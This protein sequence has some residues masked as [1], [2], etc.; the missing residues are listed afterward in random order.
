MKKIMRGF[1]TFLIVASLSWSLPVLGSAKGVGGEPPTGGAQYL[2]ES[3]F[4][5]QPILSEASQGYLR[6]L[7]IYFKYRE[8]DFNAEKSRISGSGVL[9]DAAVSE[10]E[11]ARTEAVESI[12][13]SGGLDIMDAAVSVVIRNCE[14]DGELIHVTAYEWTFIDYDDLGDDIV[15]VDVSGFGTTHQLTLVTDGSACRILGDVYDESD[16]DGFS[17]SKSEVQPQVESPSASTVSSDA[18]PGYDPGAA[19][20]YADT[21]VWN[22]ADMSASG[23]FEE[24]YNPEYYNFNSVGGDCTNYVS[25]CLYAGG[26]PQTPGAHSGYD[27]W[28]FSTENNRSDTWTRATILRRWLGN[29]YG[30]I[31]DSPTDADV[32]TGSPVFY[33]RSGGAVWNHA[34]ICVGVNS[35]GTPIVNSHNNDRYHVVWNYWPAGTT[36]ST[37]QLT[38][39]ATGPTPKT[40]KLSI[41]TY[42]C[43]TSLVTGADFSVYGTVTSEQSSLQSAAVGVYDMSGMLMTGGSFEPK[44]STAAL[45]TL[46]LKD[47]PRRVEAGLVSL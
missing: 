28:Y 11:K 10:C 44:M 22:G 39:K 13:K 30:R 40:D 41:S 6:D 34:T 46:R 4:E 27:C 8:D 43:P 7:Y 31:V 9:K 20:K 32:Y 14:A 47:Q 29:N 1:V 2:S 26:L 19:V 37:V 3:W 35:A 18:C 12:S 16:I 42:G 15:N 38:T 33:S 21:H 36:I 45:D 23:V 25:Q 5:D 24:Y 17:T